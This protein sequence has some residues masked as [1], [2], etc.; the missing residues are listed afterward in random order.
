[1]GSR[2]GSSSISTV[3][4][5]SELTS[6]LDSDTITK[7]D[8]D[9]NVLSCWH[10]HKLTYPIL[11]LLTKDVLTVPTSIISSGSTFSLADKV[12]EEHRRHLALDMVDV[13]SC[14]KDW[15]LVDAHL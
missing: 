14:I 7:F 12:I 13:L 10:Q 5:I 2:L 8:E 6:Y 3:A 4:S 11:S 1:V 15:E 9:F